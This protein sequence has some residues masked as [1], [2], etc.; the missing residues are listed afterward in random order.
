MPVKPVQPVVLKNLGSAGLNTQSPDS[1]LGPE[2]LTLADN[3]VFDYQGRIA[4]RKGIKQVSKTV[5][6]PIKSIAG[7]IKPNRTREYY[8]S[9]G[10]N[11]YKLDTSVTPY[12]LTVQSF[13]G[14]PQT[15]TNSDWQWVNFNDEL[16]GVQNSHKVINFDG[17][18]WYDIDDLGAYAAPSGITTFDPSCSLGNFGRMWYGGVTEAPGVVFYSDNLIGEKLTGGAAGVIDLKSVWGNDEI[19]GFSAIMN[20]L[21]IFGKQN[22]VIYNNADDPNNLA[23]D[24]VISGVGLAGRDN[25]LYVG[26][27]VLFLS[28]EGLMSI[29]RIT[30]TDG[31]SP[32][33]DLSFSVRN[34][35]TRLLASANVA[36]IK[37]VYFQEDGLVLT[38]IPDENKAYAFDFAL[39]SQAKLPRVTT[40][41]FSSSPIC[42]L[43]T[44]DGKLFMGLSNSIAEYSDY[45]DVS[46]ALVGA[47][48]VATNSNY[49]YTFQT[50]WLDLNLPQISKIVKS[51]LFTITGGRG[52][53]SEVSIFKDYEIG[54]PF[55]KSF[56]LSTT[57][58]IYL[59]GKL[60]SLYGAAKYA[61]PEGPKEYK[62]SLGRTG[63]TI[64]IKMATEVNGNYSSLVNTMLLTKQGKI[65]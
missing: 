64:R 29:K 62:V 33:E 25:I 47:D 24:E 42:G 43:S 10:S 27:D 55:T 7:Y 26:T 23:L 11:I 8:L 1:T 38:F 46:L 2:F 13:S 48:W 22:I 45:Y 31:K 63:K 32:I 51:G 18:S 61:S 37:S 28:Y 65:R 34:D 36:N 60:N 3:V 54:T 41:S 30:T 35:L 21:I 57:G 39:P 19:V 58:N 59:Y 50:S 40:W 49:T 53:T 17:T 4:S 44:L 9:S 6:N 16:W 15:I 56:T 20:Q 12:N 14:T 5:A 52:A